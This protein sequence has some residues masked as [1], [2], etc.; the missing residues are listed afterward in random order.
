MLWRNELILK[1]Y[2]KTH[3]NS[4]PNWDKRV[5]PFRNALLHSIWS[6][7]GAL[8]PSRLL[9]WAYLGCSFPG[10][11][12][13][14]SQAS[15][16][17]G[18]V[19]F[20]VLV[21]VQFGEQ[22]L[23]SFGAILGRGAPAVGEKQLPYNLKHSCTETEETACRAPHAHTERAKRFRAGTSGLKLRVRVTPAGR[24]ADQFRRTVQF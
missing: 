19:H 20:S 3:A 12:A 5:F 1:D 4:N 13:H 7:H 16:Q 6:R 24:K 11:D 2:I 22:L 10:L 15:S 14:R 17:L 18:H 21:G 23:V 9:L 8:K